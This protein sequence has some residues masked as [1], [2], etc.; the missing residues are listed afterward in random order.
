[1]IGL[2]REPADSREID[3]I[4]EVYRRRRRAIAPNLYAPLSPSVRFMLAEREEALSRLL[5]TRDLYDLS[6]RRILEVGCGTGVELVRCLSYGATPN[7]LFGVDVLM[8]ELMQMTIPRNM[9]RLAVADARRLP[10]HDNSFD[11]VTQFTVFTSMLND[12]VRYR[13]AREMVRVLRPTG[14]MIWY[15]FFRNN[16]LNR[17]VRPV[18]RSDL[19]RLFP[20]CR[21]DA[22][23][24]TLAPPLSRVLAP[25]SMMAARFARSLPFLRS[26]L[27]AIIWPL[28]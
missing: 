2:E 17:D 26:H 27:L 20:G 22:H 21:I 5:S 8:E 14:F 28:S 9:I 4:R 25:R 13:A 7:H 16:P 1:V 15:D 24:V 18:T 12:V 6:G 19:R 10:F 23:R 3:R 11:V